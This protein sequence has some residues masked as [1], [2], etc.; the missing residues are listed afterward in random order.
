[1]GTDVYHFN[2]EDGLEAYKGDVARSLRIVRKLA[3]EHGKV[4]AFTETGLEGVTMPEWYSG[5]LL[6]LL[7]ENPVSYVVV[8]RNAHDKPGHYYVPFKGHPAADDFRKFTNDSTIVMC[9]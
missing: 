9:R 3:G 2:G 1:M 7:R 5:T 4:V 6:P 8:W